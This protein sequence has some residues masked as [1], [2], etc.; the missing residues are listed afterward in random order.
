MLFYS[1]RF[2]SLPRRCG[3]LEGRRDASKLPTIFIRAIVGAWKDFERIS[4]EVD[5]LLRIL[6]RILSNSMVVIMN[7]AGRRNDD[8]QPLQ[9]D[10]P[11][12]NFHRY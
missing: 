9:M 7:T 12:L 1:T 11:L 10:M 6:S 3:G 5:G 4:R 2:Q 8:E